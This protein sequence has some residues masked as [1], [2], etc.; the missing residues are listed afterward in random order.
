[1]ARVV[2][3]EIIVKIGGKCLHEGFIYQDFLVYQVGRLGD[4]FNQAIYYIG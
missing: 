4:I 2:R 3:S 1:M